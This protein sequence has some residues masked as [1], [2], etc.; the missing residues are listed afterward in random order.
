MSTQA[1]TSL[2]FIKP[3]SSGDISATTVLGAEAVATIAKCGAARVSLAA[4]AAV[5]LGASTAPDWGDAAPA[6]TTVDNGAE[7][8]GAGE[9]AR[10][11][12]HRE[13]VA[14]GLRE[15]PPLGPKKIAVFA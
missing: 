12:G 10:D 4:A 2:V 5:A 8:P 14:P 6:D 13:H 1:T 3:T 9:A 7:V 11:A 15:G